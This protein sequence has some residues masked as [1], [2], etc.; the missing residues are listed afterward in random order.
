MNNKQD[1]LPV[2]SIGVLVK[3]FGG[4]L[5]VKCKTS[6]S[7]E[8]WQLPSDKLF[9]Q[10]SMPQAVERIAQ[11]QAGVTVEAGDIVEAYD[12]IKT[13]AHTDPG[14][15]I[16]VLNFEADYKDGD[17]RAGEDILDVAWASGLALRSMVVEENTAELLSDLGLI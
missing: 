7:D 17:L 4:I 8:K 1:S 6:G 14:S 10:E 9:W 16:V 3:H 12:L 13:E 11:E 15:H 2:V 5:L